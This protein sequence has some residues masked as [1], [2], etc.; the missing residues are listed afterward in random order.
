MARQH[1]LCALLV[2]A[3]ASSSVTADTSATAR[4]A[5]A[6]ADAAAAVVPA[7]SGNADRSRAHHEPAAPVPAAPPLAAPTAT[8]HSWAGISNYYLWSCNATVR[9]EALNAVRAAGLRVV[10]VFLVSTTGGGSVAACADTPTPDLEP[11]VVGT[12]D[13]T[14]LQRLDDLLH[15]AAERGLKLTVALHDRWSLGC[16]RTDAYATKYKVP[17]APSCSA[18]PGLNDPTVFYESSEALADFNKRISHILTYRSVRSC[19]VPYFPSENSQSLMI[20]VGDNIR[21]ALLA[22][23]HWPTAGRMVRGALLCR[24]GERSLRPRQGHAQV[25]PLDVQVRQAHPCLALK[26]AAV[27]IQSYQE[28]D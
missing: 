20:N 4:A 7:P 19:A 8:Q 3:C 6:A 9:T 17:R 22:G 25:S 21:G 18:E 28:P 16:W 15:E 10:R 11:K 23:A 5:A 27:A 1:L 13:D 26:A 2:A 24:G 12:Y 14:M